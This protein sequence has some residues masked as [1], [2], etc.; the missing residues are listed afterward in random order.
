[1]AKVNESDISMILVR[2]ICL[3]EEAIVECDGGALI[4]ESNAS[5]TSYISCINDTLSLDVAK[6]R[7]HS[8]YDLF[9]GD[10]GILKECLCLLEVVCENLLWGDDLG[11]ASDGNFEA[12][13]LVFQRNDLICSELLFNLKLLK[14]VCV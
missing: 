5:E 11:L 4:K 7:W 12:D 6:V 14:T 2:E 8:E 3:S 9:S 13:L 10:A 1:M